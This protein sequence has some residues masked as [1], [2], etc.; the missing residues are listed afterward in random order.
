MAVRFTAAAFSAPGTV[1][2]FSQAGIDVATGAGMLRLTEVQLPGRKPTLA[3]D[4][5]NAH[6]DWLRPGMVAM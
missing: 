3:H 5:F 4:F 1:C 2:E 6:R